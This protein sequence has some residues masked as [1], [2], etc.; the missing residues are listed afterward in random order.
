MP[1][2]AQPA[3]PSLPRPASP[4]VPL[5]VHDLNVAYQSKVVVWDVDFTAPPGALVAI[6]GP[7]GAGKSTLLKATLGLIPAASGHITFFGRPYAE[8]RHRVGYVPQRESVDWDFPVSAVDV[9]AM[10]LYRRLGW[11]R[12]VGR[13]ERDQARA[14]LEKV[15][16]GTYADRQISQLSGGQQQRVFLARALAQEA[17]LYLMDE[18]FASVDAATERAIVDVLRDLRAQGRT[19]VCVHHDLP[20][21]PEYFDHV[22][23]LNMRIV[24]QGPVGETFTTENLRKTYGA[25]LTLLEEAAQAVERARVQAQHRDAR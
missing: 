7:N 9:V 1:S 4:A 18:P 3:L 19:V 16:L 10:G 6:V 23:L 13:K 22:A 8:V 17:D 11:C 2:A 5:E 12:P 14:A 25:R 21:V 15:G 24:A 20:T